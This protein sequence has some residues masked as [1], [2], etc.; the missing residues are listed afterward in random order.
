[1]FTDIVESTKLLEAVGDDDW[2]AAIRWHNETLQLIFDTTGGEVVEDTGD[3]FFVAFDDPA[4]AVG[5]GIAIQ[6]ARATVPVAPKIR[7]GIHTDEA[8]H[9]GENYRG[10][11]VHTAARIAGIGG[12]GEIYASAASVAE[13]AFATSEPRAVELKGIDQPVEVVSID[14]RA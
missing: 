9:I 14:W 4:Q 12:A 13:L 8:I 3:G 11:G 2:R 1:M 7:I 10:V 6:R 5:A